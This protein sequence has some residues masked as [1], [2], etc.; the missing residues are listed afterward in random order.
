LSIFQCFLDKLLEERKSSIF[1]TTVATLYDIMSGMY[2]MFYRI[3]R[4]NE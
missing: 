2:Y 4:T 1:F 3:S